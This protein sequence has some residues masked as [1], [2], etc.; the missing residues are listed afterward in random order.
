MDPN[1]LLTQFSNAGGHRISNVLPYI[2]Q[3]LKMRA[4][5]LNL[6][7]EQL[8]NE[9]TVNAKVSS[10]LQN[11]Q[12]LPQEQRAQAW[13]EALPTLSK[14][15]PRTQWA[16]M[17]P[18]DDAQ[19]SAHLGAA[20]VHQ[21]LLEAQKTKQEMATSAA[22]AGASKAQAEKAEAETPGALAESHIKTMQAVAMQNFAANPQTALQSI[23][24]ILPPS[25]PAY[26][27]LNAALKQKFQGALSMGD[28]E[29]AKGVIGDAANY[30]RDI[31]KETDPTV[32]KSRIAEAVAQEQA[33]A[34]LKVGQAIAT[35]KALRAGDNPAVAGVA[36]ASIGTVQNAAIKAD[37]SYAA[38]KSATE[39]LGRTIDLA[40][41]GNAAA[42]ANVA[43]IGAAQ[44]GAVNGIKR[45]NPQLLESYGN[46]GSL[47][48]EIQGKLSH[49]EGTGPL[50][51]SLL[52]EIRQL[53][54][55]LGQQSY[56]TY[57]DTLN[58]LNQR[59]G[60]KYAPALPPPNIS[61]SKPSGLPEI[62]SA[63]EYAKLPKGAS[64]TNNGVPH[65][66]Q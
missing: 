16:S 32:M 55:S 52:E 62:T 18:A 27:P 22:S 44:V 50:P 45:L 3:N 34:P 31:S 64:Y 7:K 26:A 19:I 24:Q 14:L 30:I 28:M 56:Q 38:A 10:V 35:A 11:I 6:T 43:A 23:D 57:T 12:D 33:T 54:Q 2:N 17:N 59:T 49:W 47:L 41:Q 63:D 36:P 51:P 1:W 40:E 4:D 13:Q 9:G 58:T 20:A 66:K 42:G 60:S 8:A 39:T 25:N 48:Q 21:S 37:E 15:D 46:A 5:V 65:I 53:H 29:T 61:K